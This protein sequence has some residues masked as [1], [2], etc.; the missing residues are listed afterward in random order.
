MKKSGGRRGVLGYKGPDSA[1]KMEI[2]VEAQSS[3]THTV[4]G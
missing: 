3:D 2:P 1:A 4:E